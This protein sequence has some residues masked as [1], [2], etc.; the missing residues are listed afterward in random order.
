MDAASH[1]SAPAS[2]ARSRRGL[3]RGGIWNTAVLIIALGAGGLAISAGVVWHQ[4]VDGA[5]RAHDTA[6]ADAAADRIAAV[7]NGRI[8]ELRGRMAAL[9]EASITREALAS[10]DTDHITAASGELTEALT[11]AE[12]VALIPPGSAD[13]D[14]DAAVPISWAARELIQRAETQPLVGPEGVVLDDQRARFYAAHRVSDGEALLGVVF[15][16]WSHDFF[17]APL[18][19][20][21]ADT[22]TARLVQEFEGD[23]VALLTLGEA[24][25]GAQPA[26]A[27]QRR[28]R[29]LDAPHWTLTLKPQPAPAA[30]AAMGPVISALAVALALLLAG[31]MLGFSRLSRTLS[32]DVN[33]LIEHTGNLL[34]GRR[35]SAQRYALPVFED[36][37]Q[38]IARMSRHTSDPAGSA[39]PRAAPAPAG[40]NAAPADAQP[41]TD[42]E[43]SAMTDQEHDGGSDDD[44]LDVRPSDAG[45]PAPAAPGAIALEPEIF[46]SYDIRGITTSNLTEDVVYWIGRAFAA[47]AADYQQRRVAVGRDGR[48]S[49]PPLRDALT[50]GLAEGGM[51]VIDIGEVPTPVL[52][53]AT[54]ELGTGTGIML[55]GS[56]NPPEYNGIKMV[57]DG[58]TLAEE[59]IQA[60]RARI[61][62]NRLT[63]GT[64]NVEAVNVADRYLE[65]IVDDV[66]VAQPLK[67]VVDCGNGVAGNLA[68]ELVRQLGCEVVPLYCEVDG[69]FPNHHP[70]PAE[71][72]NL[73][74]LIT[75]VQAESADL[76]LAF[77]GDGDR[78]G[79][80][81]GTGEVVW[82]DKLL[83]VYAQ[84][85]VGRNPGADIIYDVKC[86]RHLS[87]LISDLGG[88]PIMW[89]TGHSHIKAKLKETG[90]LLAGEFSGHI[91]F[92][93]RWYGFDDALYAAA[94]LLEI[95]GG[96][97]Q[98]IDELVAQFP[99]T[100]STP[101]IKVTTTEQAKFE[102]VDRLAGEG[103][104]GT[105]AITAID[106]LRVDFADGWGL[107]RPSNTS[108]VLSLRFEADD[109]DA[110]ER[111]QALFQ[112]QLTRIAP[113]LSF[114]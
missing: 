110:L 5:N 12:R 111:I 98:S 1:D 6:L 84:D 54:H 62:E 100:F 11:H 76:G 7:A 41:R 22:G 10:G 101:E 16:A 18:Q 27:P 30:V 108:P 82:P 85:I 56:H 58:V 94:R 102:I 114:R 47:E 104:F 71:P 86:S 19:A 63:T 106:G 73:E 32:A 40:A 45:E 13:V 24:P 70:D 103:D 2:I 25:A 113:D 57:L 72:A 91:C 69:D 51:D 33:L 79:V 96:T 17:A 20:V 29:A 36:V 48:H 60:L 23:P 68:P 31:V 83:M 49:S 34:R 35:P 53:F 87:S 112:E 97:D 44:F 55:T 109:A 37:E 50:R 95:V 15:V 59:R 43:E 81:T 4:V 99:V 75:V 61:E 93:E 3:L 89:K 21:A 64:G 90:A 77:D 80:V 42:N 39:A 8:S 78:L 52:Y 14:L 9:A 67:V 28:S 66:V 26:G 65:K 107:I 105:G 88:R 74:D 38:E 92:G 46:R